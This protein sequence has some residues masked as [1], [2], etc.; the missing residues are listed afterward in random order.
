MRAF[1]CAKKAKFGDNPHSV[2]NSNPESCAH[3]CAGDKKLLSNVGSR[4]GM[5][6]MTLTDLS[7][8]KTKKSWIR[9]PSI[10]VRLAV[11]KRASNLSCSEIEG[12]L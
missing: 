10:N 2:G 1:N 7:C 8:R 4:L 6:G 3:I 5:I 9:N 11:S 12:R